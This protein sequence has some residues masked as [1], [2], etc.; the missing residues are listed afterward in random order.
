MVADATTITTSANCPAGT[1]AVSAQ[2][3]VTALTLGEAAPVDLIRGTDRSRG[4]HH[5]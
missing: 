1:S 2:A 3:Q 5:H 4:D